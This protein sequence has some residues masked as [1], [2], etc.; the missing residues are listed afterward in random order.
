[1]SAADG[2]DAVS[3]ARAPGAPA[4]SGASRDAPPPPSDRA[5]AP[6]TPDAPRRGLADLLGGGFGWFERRIDPFADTGRP[7]PPAALGAFLAWGLRDVRRPVAALGALS[8]AV[9]A[10][11]AG[12]FWLLGTL[13]DRAQAAGPER[14]LRDEW[15]WIAALLV[16]LLVVKPL[17]TVAQG[18]MSSLTV[19]PGLQPMTIWRLHRHTLGQSMRFFEEDF[20]GRIAQK[21]MQTANALTQATLETLNALGLMAAYMVAMTAALAAA[22][23]RLASIGVV[24]ACAYG[25]ALVWILPEVRARAT[26][27]AEARA[28][29]TGRLVDSLTHIR[30]VKLFAHARREEDSARRALARFRDAAVAFGRPLMA[31][32]V[33]L[34]ALNTAVTV[35]MV[36]AALALWLTGATTVGVL[37]MA[38]MLVLR[39]TAMSNWIAFSAMGVFG[40]IGTIEDGARTLAKPHEITDAPAARDPVRP[41][42]GVR[43]EGVTFR[44]GR[45]TGGVAGLDLTVAAG[46]KVGLVGPSGA[47]K[48]TAVSLLL[49]LYDPEAGRVTLDGVDL[50]DLTQDGLRRAI[51]AVT[52]ETAIFNR[53][54]LDNILYG[55]PEAGREAAERAARRAR[56]H[57]F[58]ATLRDGKGRTGYDAHLGERGVKLSGGQRQRVALA[59]A[60][61]KDAPIL[62][63]DEAT[64]AL[65]SEVEA[66]I[67]AALAEAMQG[68]TVIAIAHRLSTIAHMDRIVAMDGGRVVEDG[69]HAELLARGGL[70]AGLW[71]RQ[72]GGFLGDGARAAAE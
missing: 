46:E 41:R 9:G 18:A 12:V 15:P 45:E 7:V 14:F 39:A 72:S 5:D 63:L 28:A 26:A 8:L 37:A 32:R 36:G 48:S 54:A 31:M 59:R 19:G 10:V 34:T 43:F 29:V 49:R 51:A 30:T 33:A 16:T 67:Q 25:A 6:P 53:S 44:Y 35:A 1:L 52:Q 64:S 21:Q 23:W 17:T 3:T 42:G 57:D 38:T 70:Y 65:D 56:A 27:R 66:E 60:I 22:D 11:E 2:A 20:T 24:W 55:R 50:R 62:L 13:V 58:V 71:A 69:T 4:P 40:E 47:G 68:K 61:L